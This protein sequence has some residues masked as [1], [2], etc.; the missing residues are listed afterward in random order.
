MQ[1]EV[2]PDPTAPKIAT[3]VYRPRSERVSQ[4]G[5]KISR[6]SSGVRIGALKGQPAQ[7]ANG[8]HGGKHGEVVP[9]DLV[10]QRRFSDLIR[11]VKLQR[12]PPAV[13]VDQAVE[14][15]G[16]DRAG[17]VTG[18]LCDQ[19]RFQK[20]AFMDTLPTGGIFR[21]AEPRRSVLCRPVAGGFARPATAKRPAAPFEGFQPQALPEFPFFLGVGLPGVGTRPGQDHRLIGGDAARADPAAGTCSVSAPAASSASSPAPK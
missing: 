9:V 1:A 5:L 15:H 16:Q 7:D 10:F 2:L 3:A 20:R 4:E 12:Y 13:R 18:K 17:E 21:R 14:T 8:S 11:T 6:A 19:G